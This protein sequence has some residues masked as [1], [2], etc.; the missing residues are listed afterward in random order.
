MREV[1]FQQG[2]E[3][4][5]RGEPLAYPT[6]TFY[7]LGVDIR[8]EAALDKL[9]ALKGR[10]AD[11]T[12]S[13]L[14]SG[15]E[16]LKSL[17][18]DLDDKI[19]K[20]INNFLPGPL[21]LVLPARAGLLPKLLSAGGYVGLRWSSDS[22]AQR[23]VRDFGA[24]ITTTSAN[25]SGKPAAT[26]AAELRDYFG[27]TDLAWLNGG[28]LPASKGSTVV[29]VENESLKLIRE[30]EIPFADLEKIFPPLKKGG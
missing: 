22:L 27:D 10:G 28:D 15:L 4:L 17:V 3:T 13:V 16:E 12:V 19:L 8:Q 2:L 9:F 26:K 23:L 29:K 24:P 5:R 20:I 21:T 18:V 30:G 7:G 11:R 1:D 14:V 25:L 6:E